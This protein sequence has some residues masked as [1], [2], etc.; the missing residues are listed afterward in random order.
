MT[1]QQTI[2]SLMQGLP[3]DEA[4][5]LRD[6]IQAWPMHDDE[7]Q[8]LLDANTGEILQMFQ[9]L[10]PSQTVEI[11]SSESSLQGF[12]SLVPLN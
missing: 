6:L 9:S 4:T 5:E 8:Q 10:Q 12:T 11:M 1:I 2:E 3:Q 7:L